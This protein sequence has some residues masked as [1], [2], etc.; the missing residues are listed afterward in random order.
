MILLQMLSVLFALAM[1][2]WSYLSYRR[3]I[4]HFLEMAFWILAWSTFAVGVVFPQSTSVLL[5][6]LRINRAMDLFMI[7][8]FILVW[9]VVFANHLETRRLRQRLQELVREM[10][11][12]DGGDP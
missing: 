11:I 6:P 5:E 12:K 10:A 9:L 7:L 2:Y 3:H 8:G 1:V 4:I